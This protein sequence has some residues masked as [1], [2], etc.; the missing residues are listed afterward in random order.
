MSAYTGQF[1]CGQL[2]VL[3]PRL[4]GKGSSFQYRALVPFHQLILPTGEPL[5]P[6]EF[7]LEFLTHGLYHQKLP[8]TMQGGMIIMSTHSPLSVLTAHFQCC[9]LCCGTVL[10]TLY[11]QGCSKCANTNNTSLTVV[12]WQGLLPRLLTE[13]QIAGFHDFNNSYNCPKQWK[14]STQKILN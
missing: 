7:L 12:T 2:I 13:G 4:V 5:F 9:T 3:F 11:M 14:F 10:R 8:A 1:P 6:S